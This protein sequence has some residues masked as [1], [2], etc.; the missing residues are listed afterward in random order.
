MGWKVCGIGD[1]AIGRHLAGRDRGDQRPHG[2]HLFLGHGRHGQPNCSR[3][4]FA[5]SAGL[6]WATI[7]SQ[8]QSSR[9]K[10]EPRCPLSA[11]MR[12]SLAYGGGGAG[13]ADQDRGSALARQG[14]RAGQLAPVGHHGRDADP[15]PVAAVGKC[16]EMLVEVTLQLF[17][18]HLAPRP[19]GFLGARLGAVG[20]VGRGQ[21]C[22]RRSHASI[23]RRAPPLGPA[24]PVR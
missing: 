19:V 17:R 10:S 6:A 14:N 23:R 20:V 8:S 5:V 2:L 1:V 13:G 21:S 24:T 7:W 3:I 11:P 15:P 12:P 9:A 4:S 18:G 22:C 16:D